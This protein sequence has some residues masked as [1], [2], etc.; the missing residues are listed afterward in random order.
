MTSLTNPRERVVRDGFHDRVP[1]SPDEFATAWKQSD[2]ARRLISDIEAFNKSHPI[3]TANHAAPN[4][5]HDWRKKL[6]YVMNLIAYR[7]N[8]DL[9]FNIFFS[10]V[11]LRTST[12][13]IPI[14][15][16]ILVCLQRGFQRLRNLPG[17]VIGSVVANGILALVIG[18]VYYNLP[19]TSDSMEKRALLIFLSTLLTALTPSFEVRIDIDGISTIEAS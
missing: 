4:E 12:Y 13:F 3:L 10:N 7:N 16:Q 1:R 18:S 8:T 17:P 14:H 15:T 5:E 19:G 6:K 11:R 2:Q 9:I